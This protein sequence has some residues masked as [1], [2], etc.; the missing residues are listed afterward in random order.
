MI[1]EERLQEFGFKLS[2]R[3]SCQRTNITLDR[4]RDEYFDHSKSTKAAGASERDDLP[5]VN[6]FVDWLKGFGLDRDSQVTRAHAEKYQRNPLQELAQASVRHC[7]YAASG[8]LTFAVRREYPSDNVVK[9]VPKVK[10][11]K[12]PSCQTWSG[13][14]AGEPSCDQALRFPGQACRA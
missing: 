9:N 8:L 11:R 14:A 12:S 4:L 2:K 1:A 10:V 5:R 3:Q 7:K 13:N 6:R